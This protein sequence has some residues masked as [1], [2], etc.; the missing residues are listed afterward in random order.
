LPQRIWKNAEYKKSLKR[1]EDVKFWR[2]MLCY[3]DQR[4]NY[5]PR[6]DHCGQNYVCPWIRRAKLAV[7]EYGNSKAATTLWF[8]IQATLSSDATM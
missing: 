6:G 5:D 3:R 7:V 8:L 4:A 1:F 2:E